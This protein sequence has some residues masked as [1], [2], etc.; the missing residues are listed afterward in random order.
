MTNHE[1]L[2]VKKGATTDEIKKAYRKLA[3]QHHPDK[4]GDPE[5]FKKINAAYQELIKNPTIDFHEQEAESN[6]W[7]DVDNAFKRKQRQQTYSNIY[8]EMLRNASRQ[9]AYRAYEYPMSNEEI[10]REFQRKIREETI[11]H[12]QAM[13]DINKWLS[14]VT[15]NNSRY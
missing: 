15:K 7:R 12:Q 2:G 13:S 14:D 4:G 1:I 5:M 11:R 10:S 8:E 9:Q 6:F 3:H